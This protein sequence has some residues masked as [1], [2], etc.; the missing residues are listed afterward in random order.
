M[1]PIHVM[2]WINIGVC[3][4]L[5]ILVI[6]C[7]CCV[8]RRDQVPVIY[9]TNLLISNLIQMCTIIIIVAKPDDHETYM[10]SF[11]IYY[12]G[13][14]ASLYFKLCIALERCFFI[15]RPLTDFMRQTR[16]SVLVCI[17]VWALCVAS[18]PVAIVLRYFLRVLILVLVPA[19]LFIICF[20]ATLK[21]LRAASTVS[22]EEKRRIVGTLVLLQLNYFLM[23]LPAITELTFEFHPHD[24]L[25]YVVFILF[26]FSPFMDLIL[27]FLMQKMPTDKRL[28][29]LCCCS[30][31]SSSSSV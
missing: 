20:A 17:L 15:T 7:L 18:V 25:R 13:V 2:M 9:Y 19:F 28:A 3:L 30:R 26:L 22:T 6:C 14:Q 16:S 21:G 29:G 8:V 27:F 4:P 10:M 11:V 1:G 24:T 23:I 5:T 31:C 12:F